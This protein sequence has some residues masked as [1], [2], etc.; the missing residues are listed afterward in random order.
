MVVLLYCCIV[1]VLYCCTVVW[2]KYFH[3]SR[4][5]LYGCMGCMVVLLY[6]CDVVMWYSRIV[7]CLC[8]CV[9]VLLYVGRAVSLYC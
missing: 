8:C 1:V 7:A 3:G 9:V 2:F 5:L 4:L 6:C